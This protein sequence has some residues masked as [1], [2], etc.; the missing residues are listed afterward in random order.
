MVAFTITA[1]YLY[2]TVWVGLIFFG[3]ALF[4]IEDFRC[5]E[6]IPIILLF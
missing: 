4:S 6:G 1:R 2:G 5:A 3:L